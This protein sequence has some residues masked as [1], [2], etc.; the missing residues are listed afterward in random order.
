MSGKEVGLEMAEAWVGV[1]LG[2]EEATDPTSLTP[3]CGLEVK[4]QQTWAGL[5]GSG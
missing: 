3:I 1:G 5:S 2:L 4:V